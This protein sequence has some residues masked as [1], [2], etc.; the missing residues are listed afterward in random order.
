MRRALAAF[1]ALA[2]LSA[3][4]LIGTSAALVPQGDRVALFSRTLAGQ[5]AAAEGLEL[6]AVR[7]CGDHL[8]WV[9]TLPAHAPGEASTLFGFAGAPQYLDIPWAEQP[10]LTVELALNGYVINGD[11][12]PVYDAILETMAGQTE[13]RPGDELLYTREDGTQALR[14][15]VQLSDYTDV[16]PLTV[17]YSPVDGMDALAARLQDY[18]SIPVPDGL[19][20]E[21]RMAVAPSGE[22]VSGTLWQDR[23]TLTSPGVR[24]GDGILFT[25]CPGGALAGALDGGGI[26]GGWG[27]YWMDGAG[28]SLETRWS[29]PAG[30]R[31]AGFWADG[32]TLFFLSRDQDTAWLY[33]LDAGSLETRQRLPLFPLDKA[34]ENPIS[35]LDAEA[36]F[37]A[38]V[39]PGH[40]SV[41]RRD[42]AGAWELSFT[43]ETGQ[44][45]ALGCRPLYQQL[46]MMGTES[47]GWVFDGAR[48]AV[49]GDCLGSPDYSWYAAVFAGGELTYLGVYG[50]S[51]ER[52]YCEELT[53]WGAYLDTDR[54]VSPA[55]SPRC[56]A[57]W[58]DSTSLFPPDVVN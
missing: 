34:E 35:H 39:S 9:T 7:T 45:E 2:A 21:V 19:T 18:F 55:D 25:L 42:G 4:L 33:L 20:V 31:P 26:P 3:G 29:L 24:R 17:F 22:L 28:R 8:F 57:S 58:A 14:R 30:E 16:L 53:Y 32:D 48:L 43:A 10:P 44:L 36:G 46:E 49:T 41:L 15:Q 54:T 6:T 37:A 1:L 47:V 56:L 51:L 52:S 50:T 13:R 11:A 5:P 27:L 38:V 40:L 12:H 23:L